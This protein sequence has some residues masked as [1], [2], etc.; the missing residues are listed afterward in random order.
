MKWV[1]E[2]IRSQSLRCIRT[3]SAFPFS[4]FHGFRM[5]SCFFFFT[6]FF[7]SLLGCS[8][9]A[10]VPSSFLPWTLS[11]LWNACHDSQLFS[12]SRDF[13]QKP[14]VLNMSLTHGGLPSTLPAD[15]LAEL[16]ET[17]AK[18]C[19]PGTWTQHVSSVDSIC[20][21]NMTM[22]RDVFLGSNH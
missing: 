8:R 10:C 13:V 17:A 1:L 5:F 2:S 21:P 19:S 15:V 7:S 9:G 12:G 20:K 4:L 3:K 14:T 6:S 22:Q 11:R 18:L 16:K